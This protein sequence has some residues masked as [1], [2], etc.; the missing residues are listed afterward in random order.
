MSVALDSFGPRLPW[1]PDAVAERRFANILLFILLPVLLFSVL[2]PYLPLFELPEEPEVAEPVRLVELVIEQREPPPPPPPPPEPE[3]QPEPEP[4]PPPPE[5]VEPPPEPVV[6]PEPQ[7]VP[8]PEQTERAS[9]VKAQ[10]SGVLAFADQLDDLLDNSAVQSVGNQQGLSRGVTTSN[11]ST[12]RM[13]TNNLGQGSTGVRSQVGGPG[14]LGG[15]GTD[16]AGRNVATIQGPV[17]GGPV[18]GGSGRSGTGG[19]AARSIESIQIVFDRSKGSL[20]SIYQRGLRSDPGMR[21]TLV[22]KLEIQPSGQVTSVSVVSSGL[23]N[24]EI[25]AKIVTRVRLLNFGAKSVPVWRGNYP[26]RFFP[27]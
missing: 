6:E 22:L 23:D 1:T 25:V 26:I 11:V 8:T 21:G 3:P 7:P 24:P 13:I 15:G 5:P 27:S 19:Q 18:A 10:S 17:G 9:R 4:V 20:F 14:R 16:L 12:R 2:M